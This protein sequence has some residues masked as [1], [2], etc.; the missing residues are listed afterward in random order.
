[1]FALEPSH[2]P[3]YVESRLALPVVCSRR[4]V[5]ISTWEIGTTI[6][7]HDPKAG[8]AGQAKLLIEMLKIIGDLRI[9]VSIN[10]GDGLA[11]SVSLELVETIGVTDLRRGQPYRNRRQEFQA[12]KLLESQET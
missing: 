8:W 4:I 9:A 12:F 5:R 7:C 10:D 1:M 3:L 11:A 2:A 6:L